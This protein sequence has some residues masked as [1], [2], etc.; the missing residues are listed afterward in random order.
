MG[1]AA[2]IQSPG[3]GRGGIQGVRVAGRLFQNHLQ[4]LGLLQEGRDQ[5]RGGC[6][7]RAGAAGGSGTAAS[8]LVP[9]AKA[10]AEHLR[11]RKDPDAASLAR[12]TQTRAHTHT[13]GAHGVSFWAGAGRASGVHRCQARCL[14]GSGGVGVPVAAA[15]RRVTRRV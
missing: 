2:W 4:C 14:G 8:A 9:T 1:E 5:A 7:G 3:W 12:H 13:P 6:R 11:C 10:G 15:R